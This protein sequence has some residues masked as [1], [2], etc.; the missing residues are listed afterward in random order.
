MNAKESSQNHSPEK[1]GFNGGIQK[2]IPTL[3]DLLARM[4]VLQDFGTT[5]RLS[6]NPYHRNYYPLRE[7]YP[8]GGARILR[9]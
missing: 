5:Y 8:W 3:A 7:R 4:G 1:S 2:H 6:L 9:H